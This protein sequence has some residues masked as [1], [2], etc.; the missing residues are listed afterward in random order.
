MRRRSAV[1]V[2]FLGEHVVRIG[3]RLHDVFGPDLR[4]IDAPQIVERKITEERSMNEVHIFRLSW[5]MT[6]PAGSKRVN[7]NASTTLKRDTVVETE[8]NGDRDD[9]QERAHRRTLA[10]G[11]QEDFAK[12]S[13]AYSPVR[14]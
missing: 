9:V 3:Q 1:A 12:R 14:M 10:I 8:R 5:S 13:M 4:K 6:S 11:G 2:C 7:V